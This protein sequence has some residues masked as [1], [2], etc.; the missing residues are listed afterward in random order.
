MPKPELLPGVSTSSVPPRVVCDA[1]AA[2]RSARRRAW[3]R[4][5]LQLALLIAVDWL[6]IYWPDSRMP[7]LERAESLSMLRGVNVA[8]LAHVWLARTW[9]RWTAKRIASTWCRSEREKFQSQS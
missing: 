7:F 5:G 8:I 1:H 6:F 9:P 4:D 2:I 3:F